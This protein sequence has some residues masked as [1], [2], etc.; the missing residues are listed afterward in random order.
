MAQITK[1]AAGAKHNLALDVYGRVFVWGSGKNGK[2]G[3]GDEHYRAAP[4][5]LDVIGELAGPVHFIAAGD[6]SSACISRTGKAF[7]WG[8][9]I[10]GF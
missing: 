7:S 1:V 3:L 4:V 9:V 10:S 5:C 6:E 8:Y 2:L